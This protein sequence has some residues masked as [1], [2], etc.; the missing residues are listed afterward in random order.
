[1]NGHDLEYLASEFFSLPYSVRSWLLSETG[2]GALDL[3]GSEEQQFWAVVRHAQGSDS[4]DRFAEAIRD[5]KDLA[6][7]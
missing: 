5:A 2:M 1:M 3:M 4:L 7:D 6:H